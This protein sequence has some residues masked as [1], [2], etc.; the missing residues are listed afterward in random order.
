MHFASCGFNLRRQGQ[1]LVEMGAGL[2]VLIPVVLVCIDLATIYMGVNL[3]DNVCRDAARA[4]S[5]GPP[6]GIPGIADGESLRRAQ[7]VVSRANATTGA[8]RLLPA[9]VKVTENVVL[10]PSAP[11]GGPVNGTVTVSTAVMVYPPFLLSLMNKGEGQKFTT[12]KTFAYTWQMQSSA[13][14]TTPS[15]TTQPSQTF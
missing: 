12:A 4:A 14:L 15:S 11:Y 1:S 5:V 3:N 6:D 13:T 8:V 7:G 9:S 10:L 2:L